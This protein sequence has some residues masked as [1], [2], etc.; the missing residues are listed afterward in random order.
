MMKFDLIELMNGKKDK[1]EVHTVIEKESLKFD[2]EDMKYLSPISLN[3]SFRRKGEQFFFKAK[4]DTVLNFTCSRCLKEFPQ[5]F[6]LELNET[7]SRN[8][9]S[10]EIR[11]IEGNS[12][13]LYELIEESLFLNIP[14]QRLC[15][16]SCKGLC[17]SC[18]INLNK[19]I[20]KCNLNFEQEEE[21]E[22]VLDPRFAKLKSLLK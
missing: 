7:Y 13:D 5:E 15:K 21:Q 18:G 17:P 9:E 20:C 14:I 10:E 19:N 8:P 6:H 4:Y 12:V 11:K 22:E 16:E 2:G 1:I 3:G